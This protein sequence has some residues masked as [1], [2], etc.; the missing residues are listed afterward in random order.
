MYS[1]ALENYPETFAPNRAGHD[2]TGAL[3]A[4]EGTSTAALMTSFAICRHSKMLLAST[5]DRS[6]PG[7]PGLP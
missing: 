5:V 6:M 1:L 4:S 2:G 7:H 3:G